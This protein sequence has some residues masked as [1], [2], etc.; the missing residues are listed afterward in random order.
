MQLTITPTAKE[1]VLAAIAE[2]ERQGLG[3]RVAIS[4][5]GSTGCRYSLDLVAP[6][7]EGLCVFFNEGNE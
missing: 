2:E 7:K 3:L 4:G 5:K 6:G 1:Q